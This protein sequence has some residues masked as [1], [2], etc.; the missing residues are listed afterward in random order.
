MIFIFSN[1]FIIGRKSFVNFLIRL[2]FHPILNL[3]FRCFIAKPLF[4]IGVQYFIACK[5]FRFNYREFISFEL[6]CLILLLKVLII[7]FFYLIILIILLNFLHFFLI[8]LLLLVINLLYFLILAL[9]LIN[10]I[11]FLTILFL[12][13]EILIPFIII[14]F[15]FFKNLLLFE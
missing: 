1:H 5:G 14:L 15:L 11:L 3:T 4:L 13:I 10:L 6:F 8:N 2:F 12:F 9:F 7:R